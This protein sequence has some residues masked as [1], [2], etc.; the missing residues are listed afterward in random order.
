[1]CFA[2]NNAFSPGFGNVQQQ[3]I[4]KNARHITGAVARF[5]PGNASTVAPKMVEDIYTGQA[6]S[7]MACKRVYMYNNDLQDCIFR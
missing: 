4:C 7:H 2:V 3:P 6:S 1:M 5:Q